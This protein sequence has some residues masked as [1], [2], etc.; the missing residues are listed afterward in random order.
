M[1]FLF[2]R[3]EYSKLFDFL[4]SKKIRIQNNKGGD[5]TFNDD[6]GDGPSASDNETTDHYLEKMKK[7]GT[8]SALGTMYDLY[9]TMY[10]VYCTMY[11]VRCVLYIDC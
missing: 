11:D 1:S 7:E 4:K 9:C 6:F 2:F 8:D 5:E 10:Y 3:K